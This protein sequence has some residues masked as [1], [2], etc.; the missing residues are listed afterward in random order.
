MRATVIRNIIFDL[1]GVLLNW[2]PQEI[3]DGFYVD[4]DLR[5]AARRHALQHS[6]W[7]EMDRGMLDEETAIQRFAIRMGRPVAEVSALLDHV[8]ASLTPIPRSIDL[9][10]G[11]R[12]RGLSLYVLSNM[13]VATFHYLQT[14]HAFFDLF[15]GIVISEIVRMIKPE[16][17]IFVHM[18]EH[19]GLAYSETVFIDDHPPNADAAR[20]LGLSAILFHNP[21]QCERELE[22]LLRG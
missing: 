9:A 8:K 21:E 7:L 19:Y 20:R 6:D 22:G 14:R 10:R 18:A 3:V 5:D 2:R 15:D 12:E 16:A 1:G 11:L 13:S 17:E 4:P